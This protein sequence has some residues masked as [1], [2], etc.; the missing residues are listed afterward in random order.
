MVRALVSSVD[1]LDMGLGGK[2]EM[3][4]LD[5]RL[6]VLP[7][8]PLSPGP[9]PDFAKALELSRML[10]DGG[11]FLLAIAMDMTPQF[12]IFK[13]FYLLNMRREAEKL[14][15]ERGEAYAAWFEE[16]LAMAPMW[17]HPLAA[18]YRF[19][20][21]G[22]IAHA[23]MESPDARADVDRLTKMLGM[24]SDAGVGLTLESLPPAEVHGAEVRNWKI[25]FDSEEMTG[26]T[27]SP[28]NPDLS[29][30]GRMQAD[31]VTSVL[32]KIVPGLSLAAAGD[33]VFIV[34]DDDPS[35][36][37]GMISAAK[38]GGDPAAD[39]AR[40]AQESGPG[41]Q[42]VVTGDL[43][44]ILKW[45]T[46]F[47]D[48]ADQAEMAVLMDNPIPFDAAYTIEGQEFGFAMQMDVPAVQNL[49]RALDEMDVD[50]MGEDAKD[51]SGEGKEEMQ[52]K[53]EEGED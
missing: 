26:F 50:E 41:T 28:A 49:I 52:E 5:T 40:V 47:M 31:Q 45:V 4:R 24:L 1:R 39:L 46:A 3:M 11:N 30:M 17:A 19:A 27:G 8:S 22:M 13:D 42:E 15:A 23:V 32:Q 18:S 2:G 14:G 43:L 37:A 9:Q 29:A 53:M 7:D 34:A 44:A 10:P 48:E 21:E 35:R 33:Y 38:K 6:A 12:D 16:Y 51:Y 36:L 25:S 20:E